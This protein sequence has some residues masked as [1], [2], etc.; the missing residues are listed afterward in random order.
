MLPETAHQ[1]QSL[2]ALPTFANALAELHLRG[3]KRQNVFLTHPNLWPFEL[4]TARQHDPGP[5]KQWHA[6]R[7]NKVTLQIIARPELIWKRL[8]LSFEEGDKLEYIAFP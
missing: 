7:R 4:T 6:H 3:N 5:C 8:C 1:F 2:S